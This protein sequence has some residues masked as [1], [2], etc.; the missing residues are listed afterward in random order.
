VVAAKLTVIE[1]GGQGPPNRHGE[2]ARYH[3][4]Q[5][6][7]EILR[8]LVR[9]YDGHGTIAHHLAEFSRHMSDAGLSLGRV[10]EDAIIELHEKLQHHGEREIFEREQER[11]EIVLA[12]LQVA[13]ETLA[14][15]DAA[16]GRLSIRKR[17]L[18]QAIESQ[19]TAREERARE[20]LQN[21]PKTP[22]ESHARYKEAMARLTA[23]W[24]DENKAEASAKAKR[25]KRGPKKPPDDDPIIL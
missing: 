22:E 1:G 24:K 11:E 19:R 18:E 9:G 16:K 15:D 3:L 8:S 2:A 7:I 20:R 6:I 13:A 17:K 21:A 23:K 14:S 25:K 5:A 10:I 4:Q 12:A